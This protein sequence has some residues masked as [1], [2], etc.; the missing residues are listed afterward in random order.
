MPGSTQ[1]SIFLSD[2][3]A[4]GL[5]LIRLQLR[6]Y[7]CPKI[8]TRHFFSVLPEQ[9][10]LERCSCCKAP[11]LDSLLT[12][13]VTATDGFLVPIALKYSGKVP[14]SQDKAETKNTVAKSL[15]Y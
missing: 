6:H 9:G 1:Q 3:D 10:S 4:S 14:K 12:Q 15:T 8:H 11:C 7:L 13:T 2:M 5:N